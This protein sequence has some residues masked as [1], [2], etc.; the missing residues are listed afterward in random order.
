MATKIVNIQLNEIRKYYISVG[1]YEEK[2]LSEEES[3]LNMFSSTELKEKTKSKDSGITQQL[4]HI[5]EI[6]KILDM[7]RKKI[8]KAIN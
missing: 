3:S 5:Q 4:Q 6:E 1:Y 7:T 8:Y 2:D